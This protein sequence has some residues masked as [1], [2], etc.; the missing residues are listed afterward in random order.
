MTT[1]RTTLL[2]FLV[3]FAAAAPAL[4]QEKKPAGPVN[5][6]CPVNAA[7]IDPKY[8]V[9]VQGKTIAFCSRLCYNKFVGNMSLYL[10][11]VPGFEGKKKAEEKPGEDKDK[12]DAKPASYGPCECKKIVKGWYC[13]ECR[14]ELTPDDVRKDVCKRCETKPAPIEYCLKVTPPFLHPGEKTPRSDEDR[15]RVTYECETCGVKGEIES[16]FK[17]KPDC[18]PSFGSGVKKICTKSGTAPHLGDEKK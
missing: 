6:N 18:K 4:P 8:V 12:K 13:L 14:R 10:P 17:H 16:E 2:G 1:P 11:N 7:G 5:Q 15:A 9:V 3:L